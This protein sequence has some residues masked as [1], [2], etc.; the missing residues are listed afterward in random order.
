MTLSEH[1]HLDLSFH[2]SL[3]GLTVSTGL[4]LVVDE[5]Q[6]RKVHPDFNILPF[7][8]QILKY[9]TAAGGRLRFCF[10]AILVI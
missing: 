6:I 7:Q 9:M 2:D 1:T 5:L 4:C 10:S 8:P 3:S